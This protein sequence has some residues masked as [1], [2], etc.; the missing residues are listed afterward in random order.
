LNS[1]AREAVRSVEQDQRSS[2]KQ[3]Q[4]VDEQS[5]VLN[6]ASNNSI[7]SSQQAQWEV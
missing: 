5:I 4:Y 2:C 1:T 3:Y 6:S 7:N